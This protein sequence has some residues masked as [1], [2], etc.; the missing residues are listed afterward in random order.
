M[1]L[2]GT[3]RFVLPRSL[4]C[5]RPFQSLTLRKHVRVGLLCQRR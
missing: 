1:S 5:N 3:I 2:T 4:V